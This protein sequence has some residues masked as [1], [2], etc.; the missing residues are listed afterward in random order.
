MDSLTNTSTFSPIP[1]SWQLPFSLL[2]W[3]WLLDSSYMCDYVVFVL[4]SLIWLSIT[5]SRQ[6]MARFLFFKVWIISL[7][8]DATFSLFTCLS[9]GNKCWFN[10]LVIVNK[11]AMKSGVQVCLWNTDFLSIGTIPSHGM[12]GWYGKSIYNFLRTCNTV[13]HSGCINLHSH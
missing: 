7:Y 8:V 10:I 1:N 12:S 4:L 2:L 3:A 13:F 9:W 6:Q 5:S 11:A